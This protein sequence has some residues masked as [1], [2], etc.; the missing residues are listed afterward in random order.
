[1][2]RERI[3][4]R[5]PEALA[6]QR[7]ARVTVLFMPVDRTVGALSPAPNCHVIRLLWPLAMMRGARSTVVFSGRQRPQQHRLRAGRQVGNLIEEHDPGVGLSECAPVVGHRPGEAPPDVAEQLADREIAVLILRTA[8]RD[9]RRTLTRFEQGDRAG[10]VFLSR[11]ALPGDEHGFA[12]ACHLGHTLEHPHECGRLPDHREHVTRRALLGAA[13]DLEGRG[14]QELECST[15]A[16][17]SSSA[18]ELLLLEAL[19]GDGGN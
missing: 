8:D 6:D 15:R 16:P 3:A 18:E 2:E 13:V 14:T 1:V 19:G 7:L 4:G 9:E 10:D 17:I 12:I 11:S 5:N